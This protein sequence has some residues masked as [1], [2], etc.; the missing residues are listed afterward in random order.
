MSLLSIC[1]AIIDLGKEDIQKIVLAVKGVRSKGVSLDD[2]NE[3]IECL[4]KR[5]N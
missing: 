4:G 2:I 1:E 5:G 3:A